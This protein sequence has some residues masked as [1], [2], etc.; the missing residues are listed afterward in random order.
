MLHYFDR[1]SMAHSLEVRVPFLD[2]QLVEYCA[3]DPDRPQGAPACDTKYLLKQAARGLVPDSDHRQAQARLLQRG[4][5]RL[6]RG[7]DA[8]ARS[9]TTCS[10]R[11]ALRRVPRP[12]ARRAPR[13]RHSARATRRDSFLLLTILMLEVWLR[14]VSAAR[15]RPPGLGDASDPARTMSD[16][17]PSY[18]VVTPVAERGR[19]PPACSQRACGADGA[20]ARLGDRRHGLDGS[21]PRAARRARRRATT[22]SASS[23]S[24]RPGPAR[25]GPVVRAFAAGIARLGPDFPT[26]SSSSTPI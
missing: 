1:T 24:A 9:P 17:A 3:R 16:G 5:R 12:A 22:G 6:A 25:G 2:H 20:S 8:A 14:L 18:A 13:R 15:D 4:R 7:A 26:S 19:E 23:S 11:P 10:G 21:T